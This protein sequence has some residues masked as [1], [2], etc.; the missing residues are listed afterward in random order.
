[1]TNVV[2]LET[3]DRSYGLRQV[4]RA[5]VIK[6]ATL[7]ST[8]WALIVTFVGSVVV[9]VIATNSVGH[10]DHA[11]YQGFDPTNQALSG[12]A[13]VM[14]AFGVVG[15]LAATGEYSSG[16]IRSSL[17]AT[18]RRNLFVVGKVLVLGSASLVV[19]E[20][21]TFTCFGVGEAVLRSG[22]APTAALGAPGVLRALTLSG[23]FL[24][25]LALLGLGLGLII[26]HTAG[27]IA[28]YVGITLLIP[29]LIQR[30][31]GNPGR[32]TPVSIL[33]NSVAAVVPQTRELTAPVGFLLMSVYAA[34][35][36]TLAAAMM[37]RRDA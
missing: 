36:L 5:E 27:A 31:P 1:M 15:A 29:V 25:L 22:G 33:A 34:V 11:W 32:F 13:L 16:T 24:A 19:G 20:V 21:I 30:M 23:A 12:L 3:S 6:L 37:L 10:H 7:R 4:V 26:R 18:P 2:A 28:T 9:T 14:L 17:A 35:A 8:L